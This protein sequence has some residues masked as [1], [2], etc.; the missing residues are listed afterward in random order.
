[1]KTFS[2][3]MLLREDDELTGDARTIS[4]FL[5]TDEEEPT[6]ALYRIASELWKMSDLR[7]SF[8]N[9]I[10]RAAEQNSTV[11]EMWEKIKENPEAALTAQRK[12]SN[13]MNAPD[14]NIVQRPD[15]DNPESDAGDS[16]G[17]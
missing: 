11:K 6:A 16:G 3:F 9:L 17:G 4:G 8:S 7:P 5:G 14:D 10:E 2:Q 13:R 1:M 15:A 12:I